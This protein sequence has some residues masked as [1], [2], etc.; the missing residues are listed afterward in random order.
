MA[1]QKKNLMDQIKQKQEEIVA[2][3]KALQ[4]MQKQLAQIR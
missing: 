4:D 1:D 2:G 3:Q